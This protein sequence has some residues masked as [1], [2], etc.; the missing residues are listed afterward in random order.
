VWKAVRRA[1][2]YN[3][4]VFRRGRKILS[5]WPER[6]QRRLERH[7]TYRGTD[8]KLTAGRYCWHV[9][10]GYGKR[11]QRQY[12]KRLGTSCFRVVR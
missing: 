7:W 5:V 2:Y 10:P 1:R 4:Q 9:W 8:H 6:T 3:V 11:S 12:G